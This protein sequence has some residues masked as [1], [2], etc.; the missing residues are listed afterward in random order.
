MK[1][2][3]NVKSNTSNNSYEKVGLCRNIDFY[4]EPYECDEIYSE[5]I[6]NYINI[7]KIENFIAH[8]VSKLKCGGKLRLGGNDYIEIC[9]MAIRQDFNVVEFNNIIFG[10][11]IER[12]MESAITLNVIT[13]II[14]KLNMKVL[15]KK[16]NGYEF[17]IEAERL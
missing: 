7:D 11:F 12:P 3:L 5:D 16:L 13:N 8:L 14:T 2:C 10:S 1:L 4:S 15:T 17:F 6:L 9:K